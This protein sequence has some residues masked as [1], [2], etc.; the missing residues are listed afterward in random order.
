MLSVWKLFKEAAHLWYDRDGDRLAAVVSYYAVFALVPL[1]L[2]IVTLVGFFFG[3]EV[4]AEVL[5]GW[6]AILGD[7]L[8]LLLQNAV[9]NLG[10]VAS[11]HGVPLGGLFFLGVTVMGFNELAQGFHE[12]WSIPHQGFQGFLKKSVASMTFILFLCAFVAVSIV[13]IARI[14]F[15]VD[16]ALVKLLGSIALLTIIFTVVLRLLPYHK[17]PMK[18]IYVGGFVTAILFSISK[19]LIA[20]YASLTPF[21]GLYGAAGMIIVL[22]IWVFAAAAI[23]YFGAAVAYVHAKHYR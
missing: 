4:V 5:R 1:M 8:V 22:L 23:V 21:P 17:L 16:S 9:F 2:A 6:G 13:L 12:L 10:Q 7:D 3:Q 15:L 19:I 18:S 20:L 11:G 14:H